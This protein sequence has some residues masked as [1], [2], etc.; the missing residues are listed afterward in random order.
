MNNPVYNAPRARM[1]P[2]IV[3]ISSQKKSKDI[4]TKSCTGLGICTG[5]WK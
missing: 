3:E 1:N 4:S 5:L 2:E